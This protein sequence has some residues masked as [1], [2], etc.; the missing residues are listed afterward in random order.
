LLGP[1]GA[2]KS[3]LIKLLAN[4]LPLLSGERIEGQG[5]AIG[6]FAQH[7]LEQ[8]RPEWSPLNH[9]QRLDPQATEQTLRSFLGGFD[10]IGDKALA[11]VAPFSGG[12]KARLALALLVWQ[13][14]NVLLLDEPTNHLDLQMRLALN[15]ALQDYPGALIVVSHDRHLLRTTTDSFVLVYGGQAKPFD[16]DLDDY[17]SWLN[18]NQRINNSSPMSSDAKPAAAHTAVA[19]R[20]QKRSE[21]ERRNQLANKRRPLEKQMRALEQRMERI[22]TD[23]TGIESALAD[24]TIYDEINKI[25]LK[26]LLRRQGELSRELDQIEEQWLEMQETLE[27]ITL[28][29]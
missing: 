18:E 13:K 1:N 10:F 8:L 28:Q 9:M 17:R 26:D 11:P 20:E 2:G 21:A 23:K 3:T 25:K 29:E 4:Q 5:L 19:R 6:Y 24:P 15:L 16:G 22:Q 7:Q 12:E 14:P 27:L